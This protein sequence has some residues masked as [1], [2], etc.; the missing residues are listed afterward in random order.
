MS[1]R[2]VTEAMIYEA[3]QDVMDPELNRNVVDLGFIQEI[4]IAGDYVHLDIQLTTP[5][6]PR[7]EEI[8]QMIKTAA[9]SVEGIREAEV[10]RVCMRGA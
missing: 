10:E 3:L 6:C 2:K 7:A 9:E 1:T 4:D 8:V 5:M